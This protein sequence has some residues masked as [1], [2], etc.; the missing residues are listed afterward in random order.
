[1]NQ[2]EFGKACR[3]LNEQYKALFGVVPTPVD[4]A[5]NRDEYLAALKRAVVEKKQLSEYLSF[6]AMPDFSRYNF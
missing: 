1:M 5:C 6:A 3:P 4:Y 2:I